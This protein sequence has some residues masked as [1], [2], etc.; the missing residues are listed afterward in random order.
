V[1]FRSR[2]DAAFFGR[3]DYQ[4]LQIIRRMTTD[5]DLGVEIVSVPT[6]READGLAMSSRNAY[7]G[8]EDRRA[9]RCLS[10]ALAAAVCA[11][12][13]AD[14]AG[15]PPHP[16]VLRRAALATIR[17]EPRA[18]V[19]Y[20]EV[21]DPDTLAPPDES[22]GEVSS[23]S[24]GARDPPAPASKRSSPLSA[25]HREPEPE[26]NRRKLLVAV[27]VQIGQTRLIDNVVVGDSDDER[28]LLEATS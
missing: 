27:A 4:Q 20:V 7:L 19:D 8:G 16:D 13:A 28:R 10:R 11:A 18:R 12:R 17:S 14:D 2:P 1:L 23:G 24:R 6:V 25:P 22:R 15:Q 26:P 21:A 3:K 9:A 5:L